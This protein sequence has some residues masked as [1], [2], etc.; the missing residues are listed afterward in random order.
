[1][2]QLQWLGR[3]EGGGG[4]VVGV[5]RWTQRIGARAPCFELVAEVKVPSLFLTC[6]LIAETHTIHDGAR[7]A[8]D[9]WMV[10]LSSLLALISREYT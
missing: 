10:A 8:S 1:M 3:E 4:G 2:R 6:L 9:P 7:Q 5:A